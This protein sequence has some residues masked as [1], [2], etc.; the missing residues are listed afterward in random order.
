M[1][2]LADQLDV[3][4]GADTHRD[5]HALALLSPAGTMLAE[6]T[7]ANT[8]AGFAAA[9][10]WLSDHSEQH[11]AAGSGSRAD[12]GPARIVIGVEGTRSYG[13]GLGACQIFCVRAAA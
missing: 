1:T 5:T 7:V 3:V 11:L 10:A 13:A 4:I 12:R 9:I 2:M 8:A 6:T